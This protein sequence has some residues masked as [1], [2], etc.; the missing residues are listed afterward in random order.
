M[1][2][3]K[4]RITFEEECLGT[5]S[6]NP[7]IQRD[8]ISSKAPDALSK[9]EEI[10]AIG[11]EAYEEKQMT[12]FPRDNKGNP[13]FYDYQIKGFFKDA[14]SMLKRCK[15]EKYAKHSSALTAFK[16]EIDG[17]IFVF[18]R[19]IK[20]NIPKGGRIGDLQ[21][22]LRA[23]TAQGERITLARSETI[24]AGSWIDIEID[25]LK[26]SLKDAVREW[27]E[28]GTLRGIGQ[29]RNASY[30]RFKWELI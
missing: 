29:W 19:K 26:D 9:A 20:I 18:P 5:A 27:L 30:G 8:Y 10:A 12:V 22:P 14:C 13:I 3:F 7:D 16:K 11:Q 24:P 17:L 25:C 23:S 4:I 28:Y 6:Q 21:R 2:K 1:G 15:G